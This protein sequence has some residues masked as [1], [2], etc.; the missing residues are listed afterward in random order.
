LEVTTVGSV[1]E[2]SV[3]E[4][5]RWAQGQALALRNRGYDDPIPDVE[6]AK[7]WYAHLVS[8]WKAEE[9]DWHEWERSARA[10]LLRAAAFLK[11][12]SDE[13]AAEIAAQIL[14]LVGEP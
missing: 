9:A 7:R 1:E 3:E 14:N 8:A 12:I 13:E 11:G 4:V 6:V 10:V 5:L 2:D